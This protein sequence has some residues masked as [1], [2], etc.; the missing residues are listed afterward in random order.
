MTKAD[1]LGQLYQARLDRDEA[2]TRVNDLVRWAREDGASWEEIA[3]ALGVTRQS[4]WERYGPK[5]EE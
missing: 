2:T 3:K 5:V 4:A 1:W